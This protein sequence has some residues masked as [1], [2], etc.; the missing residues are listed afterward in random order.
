MAIRALVVVVAVVAALGTP[1]A[2]TVPTPGTGS[3]LAADFC[4]SVG[5][6]FAVG[7][8]YNSAGAQL[9]EALRWDGLTWSRSGTPN[10]GGTTRRV[11]RNELAGVA[12]WSLDNCFS[13]GNYTNVNEVLRWDGLHWSLVDTP[14]PGGTAPGAYNKLNGVAC[15]SASRCFAVGQDH[16]SASLRF[17]GEVLRWNGTKW[18]IAATPTT[19]SGALNGVAC[20]SPTDCYAVGDHKNKAGALVNEVLHW[21]GTAWSI[22][23]TPN[24]RGTARGDDNILLGI[25]CSS[26]TDCFAVGQ[27][28]T[29]NNGVEGIQHDQILHWNGTAWSR[30]T[31]PDPGSG[32]LSAVACTS[33]SNCFAVGRYHNGMGAEVNEALQWN[34]TGWSLSQTPDPSGTSGRS[35]FNELSGIACVDA[36][37]CVAVGS[38]NLNGG[39]TA[40]NE[41]LTWNGA[42]WTA[43]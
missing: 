8:L 31:A 22:A 25:A 36:G 12:C 29:L 24:P 19:R 28:Y 6:C 10:R 26:T 40:V 15:A 37:D 32:K 17:V 38:H 18:S 1:A 9:N 5:D 41:I 7:I 2:A 4:S 30:S 27:Y 13:V 35:D 23:T 39:T 14:D 16:D 42:H 3:G 21:N 33:A 43:Q 20:P 11:N 34:G